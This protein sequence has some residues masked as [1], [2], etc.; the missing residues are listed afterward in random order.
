MLVY[1]LTASLLTAAPLSAGQSQDTSASASTPDSPD[2]IVCR[3]TAPDTGSRVP[4]KRICKPSSA[5]SVSAETTQDDWRKRPQ[6]P[7]R[8][9][10][11]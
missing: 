7:T 6:A 5:W 1:I 9:S 10:N 3:R 4:S 8:D 2:K 11:R